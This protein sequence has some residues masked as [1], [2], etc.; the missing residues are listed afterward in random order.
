VWS[1]VFVGGVAVFG[2]TEGRSDAFFL[3]I[4]LFSQEAREIIFADVKLDPAERFLVGVGSSA[5]GSFF[6]FLA[7]FSG[8]HGWHF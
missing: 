8:F 3:V 2:R 7:L 5:I 4:F 1:F 6:V